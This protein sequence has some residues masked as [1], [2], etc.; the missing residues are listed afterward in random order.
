MLFL[1]LVAKSM[2]SV[3]ISTIFLAL[4]S[5]FWFLGETLPSAKLQIDPCIA[6]LHILPRHLPQE[7]SSGDHKWRGFFL[8]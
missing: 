2:D 7:N 8:T 5:F 1:H 3:T 6:N 4:G